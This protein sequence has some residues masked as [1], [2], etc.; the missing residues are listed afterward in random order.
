MRKVYCAVQDKKGNIYMSNATVIEPERDFVSE[1]ELTEVIKKKML[2]NKLIILVEFMMPLRM[3]N[4]I[5]PE[6]MNQT[7]SMALSSI[8]EEVF[9]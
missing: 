1:H 9:K 6:K 7:A 4:V 8:I 3:C 5:Y 2:P